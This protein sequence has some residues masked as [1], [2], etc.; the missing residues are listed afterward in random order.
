MRIKIENDLFDICN[1]IKEI[2]DGYF[3]IYDTEK[4][5][6]EVHSTDK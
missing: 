3:I 5:R 4:D 6:F 2:D 1:R